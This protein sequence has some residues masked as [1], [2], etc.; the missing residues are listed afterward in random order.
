MAGLVCGGELGF[1]YC[2]LDL[3]LLF[4]VYSV[5][6]SSTSQKLVGSRGEASESLSAESEISCRAKAQE[7]SQNNRVDCFD[8]RN[9]RRG[10][11]EAHEIAFHGLDRTDLSLYLN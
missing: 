9:P 3:F 10:F 6:R 2:G 8:V 1:L 7:D 5:F 11:L 4:V